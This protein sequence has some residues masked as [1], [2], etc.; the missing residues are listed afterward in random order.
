MEHRR[1][2]GRDGLARFHVAL[3]PNRRLQFACCHTDSAVRLKTYS[4]ISS[5]PLPTGAIFIFT[6]TLSPK[7][8]LFCIEHC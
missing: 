7:Y 3:E 5:W 8:S 1:P 4:E 2:V 6:D